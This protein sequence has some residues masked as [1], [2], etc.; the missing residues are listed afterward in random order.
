MEK[1]KIICPKHGSFW[2]TPNNHLRGTQCPTCKKQSSRPEIEFLNYLKI[3]KTKENR[4]K[5]ILNF[6]VDGI[7]NNKIYEFLGD[8]YHGN[9]NRY[10]PNHY[11]KRCKKTF[12]EL[13]HNTIKKFKRLKKQGYTIKYIWEYDWKKFKMGKDKT[14]NIIE[15]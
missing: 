2:Q 13:Y 7:K 12:G 3:P 9:P 4:Q 1:I 5:K 6:K 10:N 8:Y 11:N 15:Y 14:P